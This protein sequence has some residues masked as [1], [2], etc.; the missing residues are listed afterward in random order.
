MRKN[1][2]P[3]RF[4]FLVII[5]VSILFSL[6]VQAEQ[7]SKRIPNPNDSLR[8]QSPFMDNKKREAPFS[9]SVNPSDPEIIPTVLPNPQ[10]IDQD[11]L[12]YWISYSIS[13]TQL[14]WNVRH[15][16]VY[17]SKCL[18]G[19]VKS[20]VDV[21]ISFEGFEDLRS[22]N[23]PA[24]TLET[25]YSASILDLP[26]EQ[27]QWHRAS[28]FNSPE[29][30]LLIVKNEVTETAW[31]LWNKIGVT[32]LLSSGD[33]SDDASITFIIVNLTPWTDPGL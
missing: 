3:Y 2:T 27:L 12:E 15:P 32:N 19:F 11:N 26:I 31:S 22:F 13:A 8:F 16:G 17:A 18:V 1:L 25:Y 33:Y 6:T 9:I 28:D 29:H 7:R 30:S 5:I 14:R 24:Q 4:R 20:N 21:I 10:R 23:S